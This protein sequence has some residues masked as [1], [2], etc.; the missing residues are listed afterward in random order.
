MSFGG[1]SGR[2]MIADMLGVQNCLRRGLSLSG[3]EWRG[4][5][6]MIR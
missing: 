3:S 2:D 5:G 1:D 6:V 4:F